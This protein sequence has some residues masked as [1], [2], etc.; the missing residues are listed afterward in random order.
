[1]D[2]PSIVSAQEWEAAR[3]RLLLKEKEV[4]RAHDALAAMRRRMPW[5]AVDRTYRF[6][7]PD[8]P[9]TL[10]DLF[11][12]RRQLVVYRAFFEPG[13]HGWPDHACPGCSM[14]ADHIGHLAHLNARD[15]T[16]V[17]ASPAPQTDIQRLKARM[18]WHMPWYTL[19][20]SFDA[21]FGVNEWHGT[22]AF[23]RDGSSVFRT[24]F[25]QQPRRRGA[26]QHV[27]LPGP[28]GPWAPGRLGGFAAGLSADQAVRVV[29][30]AR[31]VPRARALT[32][33]R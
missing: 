1:M 14:I 15:T 3:Q 21:D 11:G 32:L 2:T 33:V 27:E 30:L 18:G 29:V 5:V 25:H 9:M 17:F 31:R 13:V 26:G 12:G 20:D 19:T 7:G 16:L 23:I 4:M 28:D 22:N 24:Y 10:P 6:E 8:G